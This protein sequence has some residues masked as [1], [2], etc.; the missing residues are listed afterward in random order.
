MKGGCGNGASLWSSGRGLH[1]GGPEGY[2]K[3]GSYNGDFER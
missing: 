2:V 3:E 1:T